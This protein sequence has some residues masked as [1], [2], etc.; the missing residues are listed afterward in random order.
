MIIFDLS[1]D[2]NHT[3]EGWFQSQENYEEQLANGLISCPQCGSTE[4]NRIP[5]AIHLSSNEAVESLTEHKIPVES[6]SSAM[7]EACQ[8]LISTMI[9]NSEDVGKSFAQEARKIHY[10]EAPERSIRGEASVEEYEDLRE[11]GID[12]LLLPTLKKSDLN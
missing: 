11:E 10:L 1:C 4:I 3:F 2:Q 9:A 5:S 8:Q 6:L 7:L 12:V